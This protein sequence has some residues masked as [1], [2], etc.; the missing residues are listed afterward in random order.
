MKMRK[1]LACALLGSW[2]TASLIACTSHT[3]TSGTQSKMTKPDPTQLIGQL[4]TKPPLEAAQA[5]YAAAV[6]QMAERIVALIPGLTWK[7]EQNT[8]DGCGGKYVDTNAKN[9]YLMATFSG[10]IPDSVW[11]QSLQIVKD[12]AGQKDAHEFGTFKDQ[13]GDHDVY[14]AGPDGIEFRFGTQKAAVLTAK[15]DCRLRQLDMPAN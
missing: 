13:P 6:E 2:T 12:I 7:M 8:W 15:S 3:N 1:L 5:E 14:I 4:H 10:P 9:A 11:P